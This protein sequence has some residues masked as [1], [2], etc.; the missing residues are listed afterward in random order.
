MTVLN[1]EAVTKVL[2]PVDEALA[3]EL[4][5]TGASAE[6]LFEAYAWLT[7]DEALTNAHRG[8][9]SARVG[10]LVQILQTADEEQEVGGG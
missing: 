8:F 9:P 7:N 3:A 5:A 6:E 1:R 10:E 4:I 2:G